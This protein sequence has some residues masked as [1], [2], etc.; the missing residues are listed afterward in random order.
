[1]GFQA[2]LQ[3]IQS[4]VATDCLQEFEGK[5]QVLSKTWILDTGLWEI[6][7]E[8]SPPLGLAF[9]VPEDSM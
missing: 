6:E 9:I 4:I 2:T 1:M 7:L 3:T 5:F 8:L